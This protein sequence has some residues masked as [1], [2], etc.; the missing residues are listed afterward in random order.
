[1]I[2]EWLSIALPVIL[3]I[4]G[5]AWKESAWQTK[6]DLRLLRIE[7]KLGIG[8][9]KDEYSSNGATRHDDQQHHHSGERRGSRNYPRDKE[10]DW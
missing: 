5:Y 10:Q 3:A 8:G 4:V 1:M 6:V 2:I 7:R 9:R